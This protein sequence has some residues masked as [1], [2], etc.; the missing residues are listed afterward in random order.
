MNPGIQLK[1]EP[2]GFPEAESVL[3]RILVKAGTLRPPFEVIGKYLVTRAHES[4]EKEE[5]PDGEPWQALSP[6]YVERPS[7]GYYRGGRGGNE[8]PILMRSRHLEESVNYKAG[9]LELAVGSNRKLPGGQFSWAAIHQL[10]GTSSMAPGP[11][12]IPARPFLGMTDADDNRA[13]E[14][15]MEYLGRL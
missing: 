1:I 5:S 8:H 2:F 11:A 6:E 15:L 10:G 9:N 13:G 14:L 3:K 12:H 7:R 4:F